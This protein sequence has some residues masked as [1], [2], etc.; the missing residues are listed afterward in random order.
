MSV[1]SNMRDSH[2]CYYSLLQIC[3]N[4]IHIEKFCHKS[5]EYLSSDQY[6]SKYSMSDKMIH[7]AMNSAAISADRA[8]AV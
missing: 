7:E 1:Q 6:V 2:S 4:K 8:V 3:Q 5:A